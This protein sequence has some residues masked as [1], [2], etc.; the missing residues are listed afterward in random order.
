M[1]R[2]P[3]M[4]ESVGTLNV[5]VTKVFSSNFEVYAGGENLTDIKQKNPI[6][7]AA[8]PFGG[9]FDATF[10]YGPIFGSSYYAGLRYKL[11]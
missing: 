11:N 7:G 1:W 6:L 8:D 2:L 5:Q 3:D 10:V 4:T 9:Y